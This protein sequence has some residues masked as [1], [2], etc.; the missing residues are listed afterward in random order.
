[1]RKSIA[2]SLAILTLAITAGTAFAS[3]SRDEYGSR[4][5]HT[6]R[7][8]HCGKTSK[9]CGDDEYRYRKGERRNWREH[10]YSDDDHRSR[11][12]RNDD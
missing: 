7:W 4:Y 5:R 12:S 2:T 6:E 8:E 3:D 11:Y 10:R 9:R 1:M